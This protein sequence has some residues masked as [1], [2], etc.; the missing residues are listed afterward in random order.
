[1]ASLLAWMMACLR[2][3]P[4]GFYAWLKEM[5]NDKFL[6]NKYMNGDDALELV[7]MEDYPDMYWFEAPMAYNASPFFAQQGA[8]YTN[9]AVAQ[10]ALELIAYIVRNN[11]PFT[12]IVAADY[13]VVNPYSAI[14]YGVQDQVTFEDPTDATEFHKVKL[15]G[16]PHAGVMT[17]PLFL[18]RFP[19]TATNRN[20]HRSRIIWDFFLATDVM[21]LAARPID[22]TSI[23]DHNPTMFN[24][25]C[26]VCHA[27]IDPIAGCFQNWTASGRYLPPEEGWHSDMLPPGF[28]EDIIPYEGRFE[29]VSWLGKRIASDTRFVTAVVRT[30]Y[31][32]LL[33]QK[34]LA[35]PGTGED[36]GDAMVDQETL[37][38]Q[39]KAYDAQQAV[40]TAIGEKFVESGYDYRVVIKGLI[41]SPYFRVVD[42]SEE[43]IT[44]RA[45]EITDLGSARLATPE[46][47]H[48]RIIAATGYP[49]RASAFGTNFLLSNNEFRIFFGG[50]DSDNVTKRITVP[51]GLMTSVADRMAT[52]VSCRS[53][54]RDFSIVRHERHLFPFAEP[55]YSPADA[56][57]FPVPQAEEAIKE[58]IRYLHWRILGEDVQ[59]TSPEVDNTFQLFYAVWKDG[60]AAVAA[61]EEPTALPQA[62]QSTHEY[63]TA[64]Q[65]PADRQVIQDPNYVVRSWMAVVTYLLSDYRFL[66]E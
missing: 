37:L 33:G 22:P 59:R 49:W 20:R 6:V 16:V 60:R 5:Y 30:A 55:T 13:T 3:H 52:E 34:V 48:R 63:W 2:V 42:A 50:I 17:A 21:K 35:P 11:L 1:M 61:G 51:N 12:D 57:G 32:G 39:S 43:V 47:L 27:T 66:Y 28:G 38:A 36:D 45:N 41:M 8:L 62:C 18:N 64:E 31:E 58:N 15:P 24:A 19:T 53:V 23:E 26:S 40:L 65:L 9:R 44:N 54:A 29:A 14:A 25:D 4:S 10:E 46:M 7:N 56:N